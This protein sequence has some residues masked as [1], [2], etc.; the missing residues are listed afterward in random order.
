MPV[1]VFFYSVALW[2]LLRTEVQLW[3]WRITDTGRVPSCIA[4]VSVSVPE[5][6]TPKP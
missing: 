5:P 1:L 6:Y 3:S 2:L 4:L